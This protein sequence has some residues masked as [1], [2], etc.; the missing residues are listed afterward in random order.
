MKT[1]SFLI[2][3]QLIECRLTNLTRKIV[4]VFEYCLLEVVKD[5]HI[6]VTL[7]IAELN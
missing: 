6:I 3:R 5:T 2:E 1:S 4:I 7:S